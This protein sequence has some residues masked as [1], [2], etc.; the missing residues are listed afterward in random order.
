MEYNSNL[1]KYNIIIYELAENFGLMILD[2]YNI[3]YSGIRDGVLQYGL[4]QDYLAC[5][6]RISE[7]NSENND[8]QSL[9]GINVTGISTEQRIGK[10]YQKKNE[11]PIECT[12]QHHIS[13]STCDN[14]LHS[15]MGSM[16]VAQAFSFLICSKVSLS[17]T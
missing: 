7:L 3:I 15:G 12:N 5:S 11:A 10:K 16:A 14:N 9:L 6:K 2:A 4:M 1:V 13:C 17:E 8:I